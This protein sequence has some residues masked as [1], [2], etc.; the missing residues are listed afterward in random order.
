MQPVLRV[1]LSS[2]QPAPEE[3][4]LDV[5]PVAH[6]QSASPAPIPSGFYA[7]AATRHAAELADACARG[8]DCTGPPA[9]ALVRM[10]ASK[11]RA[12]MLLRLHLAGC[13]RELPP[14]LA[15]AVC[16]EKGTKGCDVADGNEGANQHISS[17]T[18]EPIG[19]R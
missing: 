16:M 17:T 15:V 1:L 9:T 18:G 5:S 10:F 7:R 12:S 3:V 11:G 8:A 14:L 13:L 6:A 19:S 4:E 2:R